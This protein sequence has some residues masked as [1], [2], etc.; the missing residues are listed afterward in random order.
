ME[1]LHPVW[2]RVGQMERTQQTGAIERAVYGVERTDGGTSV[3][4][5]ID[6][7]G[8]RRELAH[9]LAAKSKGV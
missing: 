8:I 5:W 4:A 2:L 1:R 3:H 7:P 6:L 9:E